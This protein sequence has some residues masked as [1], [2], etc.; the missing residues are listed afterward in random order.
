MT[1]EEYKQLEDLLLK[2]C[3]EIGQGRLMLVRE[4]A[5]GIWAMG[6]FNPRGERL[7]LETGTS[8]ENAVSTIKMKFN[9]AIKVVSIETPI[10]SESNQVSDD[11]SQIN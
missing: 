5:P 2:V 4:H 9:P 7:F 8:I 11:K 10:Q 6:A 1:P 3:N